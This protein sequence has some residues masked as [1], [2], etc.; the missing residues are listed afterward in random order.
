MNGTEHIFKAIEAAG[1]TMAAFA[2]LTG[3][4]RVSL[5]RWRDGNV[6]T[7]QLRLKLASSY[8]DKL[9]KATAAGRLPLLGVSPKERIA[10]LRK[11]IAET[12]KK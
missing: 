5:Y 4:S 7:D 8:A 11:V 10:M 1:V 12:M 9:T 6:V 3:I 2:K